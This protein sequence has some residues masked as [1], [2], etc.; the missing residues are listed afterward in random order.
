MFWENR[1]GKGLLLYLGDTFS[2]SNNSILSDQDLGDE[3][4]W[5]FVADLI[6]INEVVF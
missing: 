1:G 2:F 4:I 3:P 5:I 6:K